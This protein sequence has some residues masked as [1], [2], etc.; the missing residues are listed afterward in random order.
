M[1]N[2]CGLLDERGMGVALTH[3]SEGHCELEVSVSSTS[4]GPSLQLPPSERI[5]GTLDL[6]VFD[7]ATNAL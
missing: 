6:R 7:F 4:Q 5:G 2:P 3:W 1:E